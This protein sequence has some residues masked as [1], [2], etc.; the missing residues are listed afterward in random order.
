MAWPPG[1]RLG[2]YEITA[3]LGA[4][5]MGE[6][7]RATD[8]NL[9][10]AVAIKVLP[11]A[12]AHDPERLARF[13]REAKALA[14]LNHPHIAQIYGLERAN[15]VSALVMELADGEEL[16]QRIERGPIAADEALAIARQIIDALEAAH[17][18]GIVHRDLKPANIKVTDQ[19]VVKVLD[20]GLAKLGETVSTVGA[21]E[22]ARSM[23]PTVLS[24]VNMT[25]AGVLL[26]TAAYMSPEQARG[27]FVDKRADIWAFGVVLWEMLTGRKLFDG[28]TLSD[29][30]AAVLR[31]QPTWAGVPPHLQRILAL[32]LQKDPRRRLRDI[33]D[34]RTLLDEPAWPTSQAPAGSGPAI[35]R[36]RRLAPAALAALIAAGAAGAIAWRLARP[37]APTIVRLTVANPPGE[38]IGGNDFD[39]NLAISPDGRYVAFVGGA[40]GANSNTLRLFLRALD[41][42]TPVVLSSSARMPFFSPNGEWVGFVEDNQRLSKLPLA[43]GSPVRIGGRA[44]APRGATW[45]SDGRI[46]FSTADTSTGLMA[47]SDNGG[48]EM[49]LTRPDPA[50]GELDHVY[51]EALPDGKHLLFTITTTKGVDSWQVALLDLQTNT[52]RVLVQGGTHPRFVAPGFLVY[53]SAGGL[54]AVR[55]DP[56]RHDVSGAPIPVLEGVEAKPSG[57]ASFAVA[58]NGTLIY[59]E[60]SPLD[61]RRS[62]VWLDRTGREEPLD[63]EARNYSSFALAPD[64]KQVALTV[65]NESNDSDI[66][67]WSLERRTLSR[68]TFDPG[69]QELP[70]WSPDGK[71]IVYTTYDQV[72]LV[73]RPADGTGSPQRLL[74]PD[75]KERVAVNATGW[76]P[77]GR[78]L[79]DE[80]RRGFPFDMKVIS[81]TGGTAS[82]LIG[83]DTFRKNAAAISPN[84]RWMAY[85]S[86]ESGNPEVYVRPYPDVNGGKWQIST[87]RG[88]SPRWSKDGGTLYF[89]GQSGVMS[90]RI[91]NGTSFSA[92]RPGLVMPLP[93]VVRVPNALSGNFDLSPDGQRLL[94]MRA[95]QGAPNAGTPNLNVVLNWTSEL[96]VRV[97]PQ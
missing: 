9:G 61:R 93:A 41:R 83:Q 58:S 57:G 7:Y 60:G 24:P 31:E 81:T 13:E 36:W 16:S 66:W 37:A 50:K 79:Y 91:E 44:N 56:Q 29:T 94:F 8:T 25:H 26:G 28:G 2:P 53:A 92:S 77:D 71:R 4:G 6:V 10:R 47:I 51:P 22:P 82:P 65:E 30:V 40:V 5:G 35:P 38:V 88:M 46:I 20:F 39:D 84:G 18:Q 48:Q 3:P 76:T 33:G 95:G 75:P 59:L 87:A 49:V 52:H 1:S 11:S 54:Q 19:G 55:F 12:F 70:L 42:T 63:L 67:I 32:C 34:A 43:G 89:M 14:A 62:L 73:W 17:E 15:G 45:T 86:L 64:G 21:A 23:S 96:A 90:T 27:Q 85:V 68:L 74:P 72:N 78:L 80:S 97:T 69:G